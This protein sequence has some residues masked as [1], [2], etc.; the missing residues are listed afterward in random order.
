[1]GMGSERKSKVEKPIR[2]MEEMI[3]AGLMGKGNECLLFQKHGIQELSGDDYFLKN[4]EFATWLTE[5]INIFFSDLSSEAARKLFLEFIKE[6]NKLKLESRY[7][8]GITTGLRTARDWK[9]N[10]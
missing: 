4:H 3:A 7:N 9:I 1:M 8:E 6:W 10:K 2:G 5:E